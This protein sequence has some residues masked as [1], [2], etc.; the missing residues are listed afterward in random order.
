LEAIMAGNV[1]VLTVDAIDH[2]IYE[3]DYQGL[4]YSAGTA[5]EG[6]PGAAIVGDLL[7]QIKAGAAD[8]GANAILGLRVVID[9]PNALVSGTQAVVCKR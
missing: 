4:T 5:P 3:V 2:H 7:K 1:T 6:T 8:N 9:G